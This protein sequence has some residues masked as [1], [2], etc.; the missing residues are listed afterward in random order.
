MN[1][2]VFIMEGRLYSVTPREIPEEIVRLCTD[3]NGE[4]SDPKKALCNSCD[5]LI[6]KRNSFDKPK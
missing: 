2:Q 4:K 3:C 5:N 6:K 1:E